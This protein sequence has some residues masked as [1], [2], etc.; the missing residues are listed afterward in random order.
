MTT[1]TTITTALNRNGIRQ[2][3]ERSCASG[4]AATG[5]RVAAARM[6]ACVP[7]TVKLV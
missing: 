3:H 1:P 5:R 7:L 4:R 2:P 6:P